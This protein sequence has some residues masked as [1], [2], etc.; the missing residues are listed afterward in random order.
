MTSRAKKTT[1][2]DWLLAVVAG[3]FIGTVGGAGAD[4]DVSQSPLYVGSDVPGNLAF[5]PSVEFPTVI[6]KANLSDTY[7]A[8]TKFVGY[9]DSKKCYKYNYSDNEAERYFYPVSVIGSN[10]SN[11]T[12]SGDGVW[13]GNFLNW[14]ATQTIDP[15]RSALT[16][17]Y[18]VTDTTTDT[19]LEKAIA[20]RESTGNF[21]RRSMN[22][23][24]L[25]AGGTP[26]S[27][28]NFNMRIDGLGN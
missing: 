3:L 9:F 6:S 17:G 18:R 24:D 16:G 4:V 25:I 7:S 14:A 2:R 19:I 21:P 10:P 11:Y 1:Y 15:F 8:T 13:A 27:W 12:C 5:V 23:A 22:N 20:D 26:A 28:Q